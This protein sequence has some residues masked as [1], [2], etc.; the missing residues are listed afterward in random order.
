MLLLASVNAHAEEEPKIKINFAG[1]DLATVAKQAE[2]VTKRSFLF[3]ENVLR[4]KRVTLQSETPI[5]PSEFYRVFQAVCQMNGLAIVPVEGAGINLEK[6][7]NA[8]GAFKQPGAQ[9]VLTRG[10]AL[11]GGDTMVSYLAKLQNTTPTKIMTI[12]TP[13]LSATGTV[14]QVPNTELLMINDVSSSIKRLEKVLAILDVPGA[15]E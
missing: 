12:L 11:P 10:E 8:Q 7:V 13:I 15:H 5:T 3:D 9:P 14:T 4:A 1:L 2:R 6:I